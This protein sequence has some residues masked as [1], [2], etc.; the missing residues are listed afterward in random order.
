MSTFQ[1]LH[2]A[3]DE[4]SGLHP[5]EPW[6]DSL[7]RLVNDLA[8]PIGLDVGFSGSCS[9]GGSHCAV[10]LSISDLYDYA[11]FIEWGWAS[12]IYDRL[13]RKET[14]PNLDDEDYQ[15]ENESDLEFVKRTIT[16]WRDN[17]GHYSGVDNEDETTCMQLAGL[18]AGNKSVW[19]WIKSHPQHA[20]YFFEVHP[21][22]WGSEE[23]AMR[24]LRDIGFL[25]VNELDE[26]DL[27]KLGFPEHPQIVED[28]PRT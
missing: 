20:G 7:V 10:L 2:Q 13:P 21:D 1:D 16:S 14:D 3:I 19:F 27:P 9:C 15:Q 28:T 25:N 23:E 8:Y 6:P 17:D 5:G 26:S 12:L 11:G 22:S 24:G 4:L 18:T